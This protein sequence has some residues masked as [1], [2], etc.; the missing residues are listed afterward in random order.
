[1]LEGPSFLIARDLPSSCEQETEWIY[2]S[3]RVMELSNNKRRLE[4]EEVAVLR[5]S[6][7]LSDPPKEREEGEPQMNILDLSLSLNF[8]QGNDQNNASDQSDSGGLIRQLGR[9]IS[10]N[11]LL[12]CSRS[13]YGLISLLN[14]S[15]RSLIRSGEIYRLRRQVMVHYSGTGLPVS[16]QG[17]LYIIAP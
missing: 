12:R 8:N 15:F 3:L 5:K 16:N 13:D 17:A 6:R 9:D 4:L 11:C 1:M 7:R 14:R 2:N 10:I